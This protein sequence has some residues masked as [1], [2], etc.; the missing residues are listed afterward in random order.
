MTKKFRKRD[1][2]A[3]LTEQLLNVTDQEKEHKELDPN[4]GDKTKKPATQ[5]NKE[6]HEEMEK[7]S[8]NNAD[9][10]VLQS[11][12]NETNSFFLTIN[13]KIC[14]LPFKRLM[15]HSIKKCKQ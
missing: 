10:D 11:N 2:T 15:L 5:E 6:I 8:V 4:A 3:F 1:N 9:I 13:K 7:D 14:F 12:L